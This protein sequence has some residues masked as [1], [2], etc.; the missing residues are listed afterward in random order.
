LENAFVILKMPD[1]CCVVGCRTNYAGGPKKSVFYFPSEEEIRKR[2]IRF[3]NRSNWIPSKH[4]VICVAHF[5][6]K[7]VLPHKKKVILKWDL[8][9]VP[10]IYIT[11]EST[12][13]PPPPSVLLSSVTTTTTRKP[14]TKRNIQEDEINEFLKEDL[15]NSVN[16]FDEKHCPSGFSFHKLGDSVVYYRLVFE[17]GIT[18][19]KE[20]ISIS[21]DLKVVLSYEGIPIPLPEWLRTSK[22]CKI[23]RFGQ[24]VNLPSYIQNRVEQLPPSEI[25]DEVRSL[26]FYKPQGRPPYSSKVIRY[27]L[28]L[29]YSSRQAYS[30]LLKE[31]SLPSFSLLEKLSRGSLDALKVAKMFL[32]EDKISKDCM[33]LFDEMYLQKGTQYQG[34]K[35]IGA[36]EHGEF[37]KGVVCFMVVGLKKSVP[38]VVKAVPETSLN[39]DFIAE[40]LFDV[41]AKLSNIGFNVRGTVCDDHS[42]NVSA[43]TK[44]SKKYGD[45]GAYFIYH[46]S[47]EGGLKTYLLF[48]S[49]HLIKN[50]RNNLLSRKKLVFPAFEYNNFKD[51]IYVPNGYI[52]WALLHLVYEKDQCLDAYLKK[53][54]K[55]TFRALHPGDN[56]QSVPLAL[57]IFD[58]TTYS[59]IRSYYPHREDAAAFLNLISIWW[60]ISNSK[61]RFNTHNYLGNGITLSDGKFE[62]LFEMAKWIEEWSKSPAFTFTAQTS[63]ALI[64]TLRATAELSMELL[65]EGYDYVLTSKFQS[66]PLERRYGNLRSMSGG[67]FLVSLTEVNN[68]ERILL[69]RSVIKEDI[70]F[71]D[72]DLYENSTE[73]TKSWEHFKHDISLHASELHESSLLKDS[74]EVSTTIAGYIAKKVNNKVQCDQCTQQLVVTNSETRNDEYLILLSRGG[75]TVPANI[76]SDFVAHAFSV[77]SICENVIEKYPLIMCRNAAKYVLNEYLD[78]Y[79]FSCDDHMEKVKRLVVRCIINIFYNNKQKNEGDI[80]RKDNMKAFKKRQR[81]DV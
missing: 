13:Q 35:H 53:A 29:R 25:L 80:P 40:H 8:Q 27:S 67:R 43:Y 7:F 10:S 73:V 23:T 68:S 14:P 50:I 34:G 71:W 39:G 36:N 37:F 52:D 66:D 3:V 45:I 61:V 56:K 60:S 15:C 28:L 32:N 48:D 81:Y 51:R 5:E 18:R 70:D 22:S 31:L 16:D 62:F 76:M 69:L 11:E 59:A 38:I 17:S 6:A 42:T 19:V 9:P 46:P 72:E 4:S 57:A 58:E 24:L 47:Y 44:L 64:R 41:I 75:L 65:N 26:T 21:N 74:L 2:W 54:Y 63:N 20:S 12:I 55:L 1:K 78:G 49:V 30:L 79:I 33:V 77:L